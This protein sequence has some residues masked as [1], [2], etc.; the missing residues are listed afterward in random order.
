MKKLWIVL[1]VAILALIVGAS[2]IGGGKKAK[3]VYLEKLGKKT[4][5]QTVM[6]SGEIQPLNKVNIQAHVVARIVRLYF[7]EGDWVKKGQRLV[8]LEKDAYLL[9]RDQMQATLESARAALDMSEASLEEAGARYE[10][11]KKLTAEQV[12]QEEQLEQAAAAYKSAVARV[13]SSREDIKRTQKMLDETEDRLAKTTIVSPMEGK[14]VNLAMK[15]GEVVVSG[16]NIPGSVVAIVADLAEI[17]A[18]VDVV[19]SEI[20]KVK[21]GMTA[22]IEVDALPGK[23]FKGT[24]TEIAESAVKKLDVSYFMVKIRLAEPGEVLKPGM[25]A[26]AKVV[27]D[28]KADVLAAPVQAVTE[29]DGKKSVFIAEG[30]KTKKAKKVEVKT[31]LSDNLYTE[32]LGGLKEGDPVITGP[33]RVLKDLTDGTLVKEKE[34][35]KG[36]EGGK[37]KDKEEGDA[38]KVE[39]D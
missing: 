37:E 8:D 3:E 18:E 4:V 34:K 1:I 7:K 30:G 22:R 13:Q 19:E 39:V 5:S 27:I 2:M 26:K 24:V 6:A 12:L 23:T 28:E 11:V 33:S 38:V 14:V 31:G 15:E 21:L 9:Q 29:K 32:I 16:M 10:R 20:A 25:T 35:E 36:K 17:L